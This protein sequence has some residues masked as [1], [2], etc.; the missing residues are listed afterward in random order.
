M[1]SDQK[2]NS[3][4]G[5][6]ADRFRGTPGSKYEAWTGRQILDHRA[7]MMALADEK[8]RVE[9]SATEAVAAGSVADESQESEVAAPV[10]GDG[11][12]HRQKI[13]C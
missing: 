9:E 3:R 1:A 4:R 13:T 12:M 6:A 11:V 10:E 8:A 7:R 2:Q 5:V